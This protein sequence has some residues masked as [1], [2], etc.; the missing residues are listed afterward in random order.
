MVFKDY[1]KTDVRN[2]QETGTVAASGEGGPGA[3][4]HGGGSLAF[5]LYCL[6][7]SKSSKYQAGIIY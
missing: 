5:P 2:A 4:V 6:E 7:S 3:G 1:L